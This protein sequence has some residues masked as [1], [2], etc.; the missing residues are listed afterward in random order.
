MKYEDRIAIVRA[1][2]KDE[3]TKRYTMPSGLDATT[4]ATDIIESIN[5][6]IPAQAEA[7]DFKII[8]EHTLKHVTRT[9]RT[10]TLPVVGMFLAGVA[11]GVKRIDV[12]TY[13]EPTEPVDTMVQ[14]TAKRI[15]AGEAIGDMWLRGTLRAQLLNHTN[16]TEDDLA[17]YEQP[18]F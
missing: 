2:F 5:N 14:L 11:E 7:V 13:V 9:T 1:W 10:R 12:S 8:L 16:I 18:E 4:V 6:N 15:K 17:K 3:I